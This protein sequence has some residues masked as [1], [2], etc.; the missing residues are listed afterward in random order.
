[1]KKLLLCLFLVGCCDNLPERPL[2]INKAVANKLVSIKELHSIDLE[3]RYY[4]T[5][6]DNSEIKKFDA[7]SEQLPIN[8]DVEMVLAKIPEQ[9]A[10]EACEVIV[11]LVEPKLV[12]VFKVS[13]KD[14]KPPVVPPPQPEVPVVPTKPP[15]PPIAALYE[16]SSMAAS[17]DNSKGEV[18][19]LKD[20]DK[21][22]FTQIGSVKVVKYGV[23][24]RQLTK[25][26]NEKTTVLNLS[27]K[28]FDQSTYL[29]LE[30]K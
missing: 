29:I 1:M 15:P 26:Y 17:L 4:F 5:S 25:F 22:E 28:P 24:D 27:P 6:C 19:E 11:L 3:Q 16:D 8:K 23:L 10:N 13:V 7:G 20:N 9:V 30:D 12:T 18:F 14:S 21:L 2:V